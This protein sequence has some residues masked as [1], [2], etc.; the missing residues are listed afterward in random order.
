MKATRQCDNVTCEVGRSGREPAYISTCIGDASPLTARMPECSLH[1]SSLY[2]E[3]PLKRCPKCGDHKALGEYASDRSQKDGLNLWCRP[4]CKT[5]LKL[6]SKR[7]KDLINAYK[8]QPCTDCGQEYPYYVMDLDHVRGEKAFNLS[9]FQGRSFKQ[10]VE[11]LDKC[12]PVCAN[13]HRI[14]THLRMETPCAQL[15][16]R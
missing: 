3:V 5:Y 9:N 10:I 16:S 15:K 2:R 13:C 6:Y 4:C 1:Q 11:E 8:D 14:R 12:D 7:R